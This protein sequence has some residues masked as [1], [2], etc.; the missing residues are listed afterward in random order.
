MTTW[1]LVIYLASGAA[2]E[3]RTPYADAATCAVAA[4]HLHAQAR[5]LHTLDPDHTATV[6]WVACEPRTA[7]LEARR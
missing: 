6:A 2:I 7:A 3:Q 4:A 5:V 1:I